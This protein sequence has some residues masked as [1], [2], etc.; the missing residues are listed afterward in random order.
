MKID[1]RSFLSFVIGGAAG[2]ALSPI[3]AKLTD[4]SSI[5]TQMWPWTPVPEDG[6]VSLVNSVCTLC[7]GGCGITVRKV[8][9][10]AIKIEGRSD[11]PVNQGGI[12]ILGLSG[13]QLLY[14][15]TRIS[16]PMKRVGKKRGNGA[17]EK[18]TWDQAISEV[19]ENLTA[20][21]NDGRAHTLGWIDGNGRGTTAGLMQRFLTAY[22]SP[23]FMT[24]PSIQDSYDMVLQLMHGVQGHAGFDLENADFVLSFGSGILDGWGSPVRMFRANSRWR[25]TGANV[26][27]VEP[28]L[29]NTAAKADAWLGIEP[30]TEAALALGLAHVIVAESLFDAGFVRN[31]TSGF[32]KWRRQVL[33]DY[34][35][36]QTEKITGV[37]KASIIQLARAFA[38]ARNPLAICGRGEGSTPGSLGEFMAVHALN[39]L[40]GNI[41]RK[42]GVW[43]MPE[44]DYI[45]WA[46]PKIDGP[47]GQGL[48]QVRI[49]GAGTARYPQGRS[50]LNRLPAALAGGNPYGLEAL[51]VSG[52]NPLYTMADTKAVRKALDAVPFV[53]S[54]SSFMDETAA[55]ADLILPDHVYLE[56]YQDVPVAAGFSSPVLGLAGPVVTPQHDTRQTGDV[57]IALAQALGGTVAGAFPWKSFESCLKETLGAQWNA[58]EKNGFAKY[59]FRPAGWGDAFKTGSGKFTFAAAGGVMADY[60]PV[61]IEGEARRYPLILVP[62]DSMRLSAGYIGNPPFMTKTV[63]DTVLKGNDLLVEV[64]PKTA[65]KLGLAEGDRAVLKT[66][67]GS[68]EVRVHLFDGIHPNLVAVPRGLGHSAYDKYLAGKGVNT[69][70][71][72]GSVEDPVSGLDTAWGIRAK[73]S[74]A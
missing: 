4:D 44:P 58:L 15:P 33:A 32:N 6:E 69:N 45:D 41:N 28:R 20:L 43:S 30:G 39:A 49:D 60:A 62:Y 13:L 21:R 42:G 48:R 25:E 24:T 11:H 57:V 34:S 73:L 2:T 14:G 22:G 18:I 61:V 35:P 23:N 71:L 9:D 40:V 10:R 70:T 55:Y 27:Q 68:A 72:M 26:I 67:K 16:G 59:K 65:G 3:G 17:W 53:V 12:C 8:E 5:W 29:S 19:A 36:E 63:A 46:A 38:G 74:N 64:N 54:F 50:L 37:E 56:G 66:P 31:H 52:S 47:A 1:R 7:P 51:F